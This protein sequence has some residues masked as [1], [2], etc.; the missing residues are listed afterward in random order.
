MLSI[1]PEE[2]S[3]VIF[4]P[5]SIGSL[6]I[7]NRL[8]F[9]AHRTNLAKD[10][11]ISEEML[12][13][14][15]QRAKGG[16]GLIIVGDI[17]I[18]PTDR[19]YEKMVCLYTD[20][21]H[22]GLRLLSD[23]IR[24]W[25]TVVIL[26]LN[27]RGFQNTSAISRM[28]LWGPSPNSDIVFGE[29]C[30]EMEK[31]DLLELKKA[32]AKAALYAAECGF[33]GLEIDIGPDSIL[34]QFL[35]PLT[36]KRSD[37]YGGPLE[38]RVRLT[39]EVVSEIRKKVGDKPI[40]G[41]RICVDEKF[42]GGIRLEEGLKA[43]ELIIGNEKVDFINVVVGTYYNQYI[44]LG[45]VNVNKLNTVEA[46]K[47]VK[48]SVN[49][50]VIAGYNITAPSEMY[51]VIISEKADMVGLVRPLICDPDL[52]D[53]I[54]EN[55][56]EE[57]SMC[58]RDNF[59]VSRMQMGVPIS[60]AQNPDTGRERYLLVKV[61]R[62]H[63]K[64][65]AVVGAGPGGL[66]ASI[67]LNEAG[68]KVTLFER[69]PEPGGQVRLMK[70]VEPFDEMVQLV[71]SLFDKVKKTNIE[72]RLREKV[73][74]ESI[75]AIAPD[76]VVLATGSYPKKKPYPGDYSPPYAVTPFEVLRGDYPVGRRVL[77]VDMHGDRCAMVTAE[78]LLNIG[79]KVDIVT[80]DPFVGFEVSSF[81]DLFLLR[82]RLLQKGAKF[83]SD[84]II[85][86]INESSIKARN[87]YTNESVVMTDYDTVILYDGRIPNDNL[88]KELK[89]KITR[90][91]RIGDCVAPR[92]IYMAIYEA[93]QLIEKI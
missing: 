10:S 51:E 91:F 12:S 27:H 53:K 76:I 19:P 58:V 90:L 56:I 16:C 86:E 52:P 5:I 63:A 7:K 79:K 26:N 20:S 28:P 6:I 78:Y 92:N 88:Y 24:K 77:F 60:C 18:H 89:N 42:W 8:C 73:T 2:V 66:K 50:P 57:I 3:K 64:R 17:S 65:A 80:S 33:D 59:C 47:A 44:L 11:K 75:A 55:K 87:V 45:S 13:Y 23:T 72:I 14:Y 71:G 32:F 85:T 48:S 38:N 22:K 4:S 36:N 83:I 29:I 67:L 21:P 37:E 82:Q 62:N 84:L 69:E 25:Q 93:Q 49:I 30:K 35:S 46:S 31:E 40:V 9:L 1:D 74:P 68:Y 15:E 81:G 54:K 61:K 70:K 34:R 43:I 41:I 39:V